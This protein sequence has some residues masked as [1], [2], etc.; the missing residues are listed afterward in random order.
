MFYLGTIACAFSQGRFIQVK[1]IMWVVLVLGNFG[2]LTV[3]LISGCSFPAAVLTISPPYDI[4]SNVHMT[5]F[6]FFLRIPVGFIVQYGLYGRGTYCSWW[7][8]LAFFIYAH[9]P[10][11]TTSSTLST[12]AQKATPSEYLESKL[13]QRKLLREEKSV[14]AFPLRPRLVFRKCSYYLCNNC[15]KESKE[16]KICRRCRAPYCSLECQTNDWNS[17]HHRDYCKQKRST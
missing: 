4:N 16:F 9:W 15:E 14:V 13:I 11:Q 1:M 2:R 10:D 8:V 12:L 17:G 3:N 6:Y 7:T 5:M